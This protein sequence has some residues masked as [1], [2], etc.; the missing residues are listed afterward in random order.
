MHYYWLLWIMIFDKSLPVF[1]EEKCL[2]FCTQPTFFIF[3]PYFN[4]SFIRPQL[5]L[6]LDWRGGQG[7]MALDFSKIPT[8]YYIFGKNKIILDIYI[9]IY[10]FKSP[11]FLLKRCN[12][13][14][15]MTNTSLLIVS[16][17]YFYIINNSLIQSVFNLFYKNRKFYISL[18]DYFSLI[19]L[20]P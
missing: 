17:N 1:I 19:T 5:T 16:S 7:G 9:Y 18:M 15:Q 14:I 20:I 8:P 11:R 10:K 2:H 6:V 12:T 4:H 3:S 13:F